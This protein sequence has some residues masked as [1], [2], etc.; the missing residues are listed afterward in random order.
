MKPDENALR[1]SLLHHFLRLG[2]SLAEAVSLSNKSFDRAAAQ[3]EEAEEKKEKQR[4]GLAGVITQINN[5]RR[6]SR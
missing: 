2:H 6:A 3:A 4:D 5:S 1:L